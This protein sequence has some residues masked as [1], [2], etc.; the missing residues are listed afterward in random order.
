MATAT[1]TIR[2]P[3]LSAGDLLRQWR[4]LRG[5]SQ[6][7]LAFDTGI[8]QKHV[9]F[10]ETG[11]S[12]PSRQMIIDL[13]DALDIPLR[14][15]NL[16]AGAAGYA[17]VYSED[18]FDGVSMPPIDRAVDRLLRQQEPFPAIV[19]DRYWNVIRT[20]E[21][22][23]AFLGRFIDLGSYPKPRNLLRLM[24]DPCGFQPHLANFAET[25]RS[26]ILRIQQEASGRVIDDRMRNLIAGLQTYAGVPRGAPAPSQ[27]Q[28][29]GAI[30]L[31]FRTGR[32]DDVIEMFSM[33]TSVAA[34]QAVGAQEIR[35]E[36]MFPTTADMEERYLQFMGDS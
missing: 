8:S 31:V 36:M 30:P 23:P 25:A 11:R 24:F 27:E 20:N 1:P 13:S 10:V 15:R 6:L 4:G 12:I 32:A 16:I 19:M 33:I 17:P 22:A 26:M 3:S 7:D 28:F 29:A 34:P 18:P 21:A 2:S 14:E 35:I 5:K 9:S